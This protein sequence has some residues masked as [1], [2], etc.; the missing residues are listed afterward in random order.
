MTMTIDEEE[1]L[2]CVVTVVIER[3]L[4]ENPTQHVTVVLDLCKVLGDIVGQG[5]LQQPQMRP[6]LSKACER[7]GQYVETF[8]RDA[9]K[10]MEYSDIQTSH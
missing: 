1:C 10:Q 4:K 3:F 6:I 8:A 7:I 9:I 2:H 5:A